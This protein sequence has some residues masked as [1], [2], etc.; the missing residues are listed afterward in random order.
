MVDIPIV[1]GAYK[2]TYNWGAPSCRALLGSSCLNPN[3]DTNQ[4]STS[5]DNF[6]HSPKPGPKV[7]Y[8]VHQG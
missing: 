3:M 2:P 1:N 6:P 4:K 8:K 5:K 7:H